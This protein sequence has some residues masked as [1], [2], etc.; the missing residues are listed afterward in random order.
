MVGLM[1]FLMFMGLYVS[2]GIVVAGIND[3]EFDKLDGP[4]L[5]VVHA[6]VWPGILIYLIARPTDRDW[7][8][9]SLSNSISLIP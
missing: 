8:T 2:A 9:S 1:I 3:I 4:F 6:L 7:E 5:I